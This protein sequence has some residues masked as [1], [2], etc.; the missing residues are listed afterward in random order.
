MKIVHVTASKSYD[1]IIGSGLLSQ[2]GDYVRGLGK[3]TK[4]CIISDSN[5]F[6]LYG[7]TVKERL[8]S[9]GLEATEF[10]FTA[11]EAS[12]NET[13]YLSLLNFLAENRLTRSDL[14]I[15]LGGGVVGDMTGEGNVTIGDA[16]LIAQ[17]TLEDPENITADQLRRADVNGDGN[18]TIA[19]AIQAAQL[20]LG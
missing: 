6:P 13:T 16:I 12:K 20:S 3:A 1:V 9:A 8:I 10:V 14:I 17:L 2:I 19:D 4:V 11:G 18:L 5:V 7:A 15:A